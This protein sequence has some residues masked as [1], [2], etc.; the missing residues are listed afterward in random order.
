MYL[1]EPDAEVG[2]VCSL[3]A[4]PAAGD[5]GAATWHGATPEQQPEHPTS[6]TISHVRHAA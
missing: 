4:A 1:Q 3:L 6:W 5:C 2:V